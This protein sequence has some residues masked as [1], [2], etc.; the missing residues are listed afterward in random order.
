VG[1]ISW[2]TASQS[3]SA[4]NL[5]AAPDRPAASLPSSAVAATPAA[6]QFGAWQVACAPDGKPTA[7]RAT[8]RLVT[9]DSGQTVFVATILPD[10]EAKKPGSYVGIVSVPLGGYLAPG[11]ELSIDSAH[12]YKIVFETCNTAG[13]HAGFPI[14]GPVLKAL[15]KGR[16]ASFEL[17]TSKA[18]PATVTVSLEGLPRALAA[19][20]RSAP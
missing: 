8:Q 19:L 3:A 6:T 15:V 10:A 18:R 16:S 2:A 5:S 12:P 9:A 13:C 1:S 11:L 14:A 4:E 20:D 7:C 17:W